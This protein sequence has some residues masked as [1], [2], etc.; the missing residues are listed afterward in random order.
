MNQA[1]A[2]PRVPADHIAQLA[3]FTIK[4]EWRSAFID[5]Q[6]S[7]ASSIF[8]V[9]HFSPTFQ[10]GVGYADRLDYHISRVQPFLAYGW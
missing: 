9:D 1:G 2:S 7:S 4:A 5:Q 6:A 10:V 3:D 8:N